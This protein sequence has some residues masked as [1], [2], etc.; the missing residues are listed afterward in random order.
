MKVMCI[1]KSKFKNYHNNNLVDFY[2][3]SIQEGSIYTVVLEF[4]R[5]ETQGEKHGGYKLAE[6]ADC[7][8]EKEGFAPISNQDNLQ[9]TEQEAEA[10]RKRHLVQVKYN[11]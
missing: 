4:K 5:E 2:I 3:K 1:D 8:W 7:I 6:F 11:L 9:L 10:I